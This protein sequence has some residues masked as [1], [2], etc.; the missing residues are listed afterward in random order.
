MSLMELQ[1]KTVVTG[2]NSMKKAAMA[3]GAMQG[4]GEKVE[5]EVEEEEVEVEEEE[6]VDEEE[7]VE[8][9]AQ[10]GL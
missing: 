1:V 9:V 2:I 6:V 8:D 5:E 7:A 4:E 10:E 3:T